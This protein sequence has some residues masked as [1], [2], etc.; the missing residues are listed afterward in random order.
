M[1]RALPDPLQ[2]ALALGLL[3]LVVLG[4]WL[5]LARPIASLLHDQ[6]QAIER[7]R[8]L[9][10]RF[11]AAGSRTATA[12]DIERRIEEVIGRGALL[13]GE[14]EPIRL[15]ALQT[16]VGDIAARHR[17][18]VRSSRALPRR[19]QGRFALLGVRIQV[20][21]DLAGA[22]ALIHGLETAEAMLLVASL[23]MTRAATGREGGAAE[24]DL[25]IDILGV[26]R[27]EPG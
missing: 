18:Q 25:R 23:Q 24:I 19:E 10:G 5:G 22:Q 16:L 20:A 17:I 11:L 12:A 15:A 6:G 14:S 8:V 3:A 2:R 7:E 1:T 26:T 27:K 13:E 21:T 4:L 9:L